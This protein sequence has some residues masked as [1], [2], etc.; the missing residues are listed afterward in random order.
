MDHGVWPYLTLELY[1]HQTGDLGILFQEAHYFRDTQQTRGQKKDSLWTEGYGRKLKTRGGQ[2]ASGSILEHLLVQH[3]VQFFNVG[4]HNHIR[5][6]SGDWNDGLD[7]AY[8]RGESVAFTALYGSNLKRLA[9][10][11]ETAAAHNGLKKV[12]LAKE[13]LLLLD[14]TAGTKVH[15][16]SPQAKQKRLAQ[17][18]EAVQPEISGKKT[19]VLLPKL[20]EDL[21]QK[22]EHI[23][24]HIQQ[25]E[26]FQVSKTEGLFNGYYDNQG[27]RVEGDFPKGLRMTLAGQTFPI[28]SG[29]STVEQTREIFACAKKYLKDK[30]HGGFRLNTNFGEIRLDLGRAFS[31][32]YGEKENGA[33]FSH[34]AVMFANALY[35]RGFVNEGHEVLDSIYRMCV[36]TDKS[37]IYP[38]IPEYFNSEGRGLY[39]YLTGS[40]SWLVLT[41]LTQV[42]GVRGR[43]GNL[44]LAP[45]LKQDVFRVKSEVSVDTFYEGRRIKVVYRNP[46]K[47]A[48]EHYCVTKV[49][50]NGKELQGLELHQKEVLIPK[51]IFLKYS[52]V[53]ENT[54]QVTIE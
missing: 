32:A 43:L 10:L 50:L 6:E 22:S 21:R 54:L 17:Y 31:F 24:N 34:M 51:K 7:M 3:L 53:S 52:R 26:W 14:R 44:L 2:I 47:L 20:I 45:K 23:T 8:E 42:F 12:A 28:M 15:Y 48:Y 38:G 35:Q 40:A 39:H 33:F 27:R 13:L 4:E 37:K 25:K 49:T 16:D 36:R 5:L 18:F 1:I 9:D 19:Q 41:V 11:L 29:I 46:K 30:E